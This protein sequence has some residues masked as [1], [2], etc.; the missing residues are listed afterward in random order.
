MSYLLNLF[1]VKKK[2][3]IAI[4]VQVKWEKIVFS[5]LQFQI[6]LKYKAFKLEKQFPERLQ[7]A[8]ISLSAS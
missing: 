2:V 5:D 8:K 4:C 6:I 7:R 1:K 3:E